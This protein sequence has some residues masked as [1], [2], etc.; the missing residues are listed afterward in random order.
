MEQGSGIEK[1]GGGLPVKES[2]K[3]CAPPDLGSLRG[4]SEFEPQAQ[5]EILLSFRH[6]QG[7]PP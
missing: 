7:S 1:L 3:P 4:E 6:P 5:N 2:L